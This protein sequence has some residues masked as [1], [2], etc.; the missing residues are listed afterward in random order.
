MKTHIRLIAAAIAGGILLG[1]CT[2]PT[3][4][5]ANR[6]R[7]VQGADGRLEIDPGIIDFGLCYPDANPKRFEMTLRNL[8]T[9]DSLA[10]APIAFLHPDSGFYIAA[11]QDLYPFLAPMGRPGSSRQLAVTFVPREGG[12]FT[13]TVR[14]NGITSPQLILR[15]RVAAVW[16]E[17]VGFNVVNA[18]FTFD[19]VLR[20]VNRSPGPVRIDAVTVQADTEFVKIISPLT[21]PLSIGPNS[22]YKFTLRFT[23]PHPGFRAYSGKVVF[24]ISGTDFP[25]DNLCQVTATEP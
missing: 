2:A 11:S 21:L 22:D 18:A 12:D 20:V 17:D 8:S 23:P 1:S 14:F 19:T 9:T 4:V 7:T 13:D 16:V 6:V 10:I 15:A 25:V 24:G 3:D 5:S